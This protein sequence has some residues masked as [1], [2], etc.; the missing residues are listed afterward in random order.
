MTETHA[1]DDQLLAAPEHASGPGPL[2]DIEP[3]ARSQ[4]VLI[5]RR[6]VVLGLLGAGLV[7]AIGVLL[8]LAST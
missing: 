2:P 8:G 1:L 5:L 3:K 7:G 6:S 4:W